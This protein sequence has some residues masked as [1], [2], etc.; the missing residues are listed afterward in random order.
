MKVIAY[1][2]SDRDYG[3]AIVELTW[4]EM[5]EFL[6]GR[7]RPPVGCSADPCQRLATVNSI[8]ERA[9]QATKMGEQL[10]ALAALLDTTIP[11]I[12]AIV[13]PPPVVEQGAASDSE[14]TG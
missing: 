8:I 2:S 9:K 5:D 3:N 11:N 1:T 4:K 6:G 14:E 13:N 7:I 10:R 12:D